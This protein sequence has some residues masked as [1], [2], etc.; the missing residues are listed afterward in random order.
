MILRSVDGLVAMSGKEL[1]VAIP[2]SGD[3]RYEVSPGGM[4]GCFDVVIPKEQEETRGRVILEVPDGHGEHDELVITSPRTIRVSEDGTVALTL[5]EYAQVSAALP[6]I[7]AKL[8]GLEDRIALLEP[9]PDY[10]S[11]DGEVPTGEG[12][13]TYDPYAP[14]LGLCGEKD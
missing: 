12:T 7:G 8:A 10:P 2:A 1:A 3:V 6:A 4:G 13:G 11:V 5:S 9:V 14:G